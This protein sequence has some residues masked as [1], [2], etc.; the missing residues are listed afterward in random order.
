M[1]QL[2][3]QPGRGERSFL[4][5]AALVVV[6]LGELLIPSSTRAEPPLGGDS[7]SPSAATD[8]LVSSFNPTTSDSQ[9]S[10]SQSDQLSALTMP[11]SPDAKGA[12]EPHTVLSPE[13]RPESPRFLFGGGDYD[14]QAMRLFAAWGGGA[15]ARAVVISWASEARPQA[16]FEHF[17]EAF[18]AAGGARPLKL[19][20][21]DELGGDFSLAK[22]A[23]RSASLVMLTGGDQRR[24]IEQLTASGIGQEIVRGIKRNRLIYGGT[25]AG[26]AITSPVMIFGPGTRPENYAQDQ[27]AQNGSSFWM[28]SGLE[29]I[30]PKESA[31]FVVEQHLLR[32]GRKDRLR[33]AMSLSDSVKWGFGIDDGGCAIVTGR[34]GRM[35]LYGV[36]PERG[37][38]VFRKTAERSI[39]PVTK[40]IAGSSL[41]LSDISGH[42]PEP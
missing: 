7:I 17:A 21:F 26:T 29:L 14:P 38:H 24:L 36:S 6:S 10:I 28:G 19:P 12:W 37:V 20:E 40:L 35:M 5:K 34:A 4:A 1:E 16:N 30:T 8:T 39:E 15:D 31:S 42:D 33:E 18:Q 11:D 2:Q 32:A 9:R 13:L 23:I 41:A 22:E 27:N 25:S 3:P